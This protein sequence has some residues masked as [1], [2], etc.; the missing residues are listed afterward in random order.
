MDDLLAPAALGAVLGHDVTA[1]AVLR[2]ETRSSSEL[3]FVEPT[4]VGPP[5]P[6]RLVLKVG[7]RDPDVMLLQGP[8]VSGAAVIVPSL[9]RVQAPVAYGPA[10]PGWARA[11]S[12][13]RRP[14][15][16]G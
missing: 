16:P 7:G 14:R 2:R 3:T 15:R 9:V 10:G 6:A 1:V 5:G 12:T 8:R 4:Y 13:G 11:P